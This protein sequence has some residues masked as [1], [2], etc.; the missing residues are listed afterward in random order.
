MKPSIL[1]L[2]RCPICLGVLE[3]TSFD[4]ADGEVREG[5][6]SCPE[7]HRFQVSNFVPR[8]LPEGRDSHQR[9]TAAAFANKWKRFPRWGIEGET[10]EYE[11]R[12]RLEK[13]GWT[14]AGQFAR[15]LEGKQY[16]MDA[17]TGLGGDL[18]RMCRANSGAQ[19]A[20]IELSACV[21]EAFENARRFSNAHVIQADI[22]RLPFAD[23][24]FDFIVSDGVLHHTPDT[25]QSFFSLCRCLRP[26]GEICVYI[27]VKKPPLREAADLLIRQHSTRL[28]PDTCWEFCME[29]TRL[30]QALWDSKIEVEF[31]RD[32]EPLGIRKGR[33]PL[34]RLVYYYFTKCY[35]NERLTFEENNLVNFDWYFPVYAHSHTPDEVRGWFQEAGIEVIHFYVDQSGISVR[36]M[37]RL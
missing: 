35:W 6:L 23:C 3:L 15:T 33:Y 8:L 16:L 25:R 7:F 5:L 19:I 10:A 29:L 4:V 11:Q 17:G 28:D 22:S 20:G 21:D 13:Y 12:W 18:V 30:G 26:G 1:P 31:A 24:T 9:Q 2:L 32:I 14:D 34:Q 36:G 27:Y 37:K